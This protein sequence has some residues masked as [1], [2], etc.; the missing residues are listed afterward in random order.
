MG[1]IEIINNNK[2]A[3]DTIDKNIEASI[4]YMAS[5][6]LIIIYQLPKVHIALLFFE[7]VS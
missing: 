6:I 2:F 4:V 1:Q 3:N 7:K 5:F